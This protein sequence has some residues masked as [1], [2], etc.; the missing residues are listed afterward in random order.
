MEIAIDLHPGGD[1]GYRFAW[2]LPGG[3]FAPRS[4]VRMR[5]DATDLAVPS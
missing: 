1:L 3:E 5:P 2:G 4:G